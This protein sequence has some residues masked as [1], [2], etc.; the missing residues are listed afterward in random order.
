MFLTE[1]GK[2]DSEIRRRIDTAKDAIQ[3]LSQLL[4]ATFRYKERKEY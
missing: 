3:N 2:Y 1:K 4:T